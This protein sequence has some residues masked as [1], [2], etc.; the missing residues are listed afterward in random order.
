MNKLGSMGITV[1]L[2]CVALT[3]CEN[4][5]DQSRSYAPGLG[6]IM[7]FTQLR[8]AKLW[9]AGSAG[10]W[11]LAAYEADEIEEGFQDA[12]TYHPTHKD[13]PLPLATALPAMTKGPLAA[14]RAAIDRRDQP[15]FETAFD[16]LTAACNSC[17]QAM[18]FGFNVVRRPIA[19][20]FP[21]QDFA[22]P[23][24]TP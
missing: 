22:A 13:A 14:L 9:L 1:L 17:H 23:A 10:N 11:E 7:T 8:H 12:V 20:G 16:S 3:A 21:N 5:G 15:A 18:K 19:D 4:H 2:G 6:E 24:G